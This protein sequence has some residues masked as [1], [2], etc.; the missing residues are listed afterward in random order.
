MSGIEKDAVGYRTANKANPDGGANYVQGEL[1]TAIA[2]GE[3][4][5]ADLARDLTGAELLN[6]IQNRSERLKLAS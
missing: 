5:L 2:Q 3:L 6:R 1:E 4:F